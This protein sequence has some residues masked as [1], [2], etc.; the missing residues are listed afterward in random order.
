MTTLMSQLR[1]IHYTNLE[2]KGKYIVKTE[3]GIYKGQYFTQPQYYFPYIVLTFVT[4]KKNG[5][6]YSLSEAIFDKQDTFYNAKEYIHNIKENARKAKQ[7]MESR[8]LDKILKGLVNDEF[9]W[10]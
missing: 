1:P 9:Q 6:M 5:T 8:A 10:S 4:C 7:Q 2:R 3:N